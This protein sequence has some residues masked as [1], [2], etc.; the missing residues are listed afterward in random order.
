[1]EK[2][3]ALFVD[4]CQLPALQFSVHLINLLS[5]LLRYSGFARIWK[6]VV[7][8]TSY[9]PPNSDHGLFLV[10]VWLWEVLW[11]FFLVQHWAG[12]HCLSCTMH[13]SSHVTVWSR[14]SLLLLPRLREDNTKMIISFLFPVSSWGTTYQAFSPFLI[15]FKCWMTI[16]WLMLILQQLLL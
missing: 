15:C 14:N 8:Q 11:S 3:W 10:H 5:I 6:A 4:Q 12:R 7:D 2:N 1:M 13:C 16:E 9:R